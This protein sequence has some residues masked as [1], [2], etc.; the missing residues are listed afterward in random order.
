MFGFFKRKTTTR[1]SAPAAAGGPVMAALL[2]NSDSFDFDQAKRAILATKIGGASAKNLEV[3]E[4][5]LTFSAAGREYFVSP[6]PAPYPWSDL[7]GPC[8]TSWMWPPET[9]AMSMKSHK[10][11]VLVIDAAGNDRIG[12][13]LALT[14]LCSALTAVQSVIGI[15]WP[16]ATVVHFPQIFKGMAEMA[17]YNEPPFYLWVDFRVYQ[18][19]ENFFGLFTTGMAALGLMEMELAPRRE[20]PAEIRDWAVNIAAYIYGRGSP[21]AHGETIG[22][23]AADKHNVTHVRS[24]FGGPGTV[25]RIA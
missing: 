22:A 24:S 20:S 7:E 2:L 12:S 4:N 9:P 11:H 3:R 21:I 16:E 8:Q 15:Y 19:S 1:D 23:S 18:H 14:Q 10:T 17:S 13:R 5:I 6:M 25:M